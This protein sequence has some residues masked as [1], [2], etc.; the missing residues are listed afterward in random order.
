MRAENLADPEQYIEDLLERAE[1]SEISKSYDIH[2]WSS[3]QHFLHML[4]QRFG[5]LK[6]GGEPNTN[7]IAKILI[8]DWQRGKIHYYVLPTKEQEDREEIV[9]KHV[10]GVTQVFQDIANLHLD[11]E[12]GGGEEGNIQQLGDNIGDHA[13]HVNYD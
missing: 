10:E 3:S 5:K 6:K 7:A 1:R 12:G 8:N 11:E 13:P 9:Q 4:A 2:G